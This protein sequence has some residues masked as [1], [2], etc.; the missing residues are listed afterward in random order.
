MEITELRNYTRVLK[1]QTQCKNV[2]HLNEYQLKSYL[3]KKF[4]EFFKSEH[5]ELFINL[6][7]K[8]WELIYSQIFY[9]A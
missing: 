2:K 4:E 8:K 3:I 1:S 7:D 5:N 9:N 6:V